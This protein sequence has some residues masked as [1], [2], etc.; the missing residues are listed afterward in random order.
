[1]PDHFSLPTGVEGARE[2]LTL[3]W[4]GALPRWVSHLTLPAG[5]KGAQVALNHRDLERYQGWQPFQTIMSR[6]RG[7]ADQASAF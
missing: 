5:V 1:M 7:R 6:P 2:V 4:R 3:R